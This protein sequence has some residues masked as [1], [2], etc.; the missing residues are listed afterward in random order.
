[1]TKI[2]N[3]FKLA[4]VN[5]DLDE[6]LTPNGQMTDASNVM[7]ISE[8]SGN[9][10][11]L[12][13]IKGNL[14]V[15]NTNI[16]GAE[17]IGSIADES[18]NRAFYFVKGVEFDY[19]FEYNTDNDS[20]VVV[21][22]SSVGGVLNFSTS[23]R[24]S[25]SDIFTSVEGDDLLSWTDGLNP[26][27]II[28]IERAKAFAINGFTQDEISVMKPS[29]IFAPTISLLN[30]D[31]ETT[32]NF[33][34]DKFVQ[35][36]YRYK[37]KD[38]Y[39]SAIS[40]WSQVAFL[41]S[42]FALDYQ[43]Y[44]N[45]GMVNL[46]NAVRVS[47]NVGSRDVI[48][49]DLLFKESESSTVYIVEKFDKIEEEWTT[50]NAVVNYDFI[51]N[52]IYGI[53]PESEYFRSF[54]N[55]PLT[56][57]TQSKVGNRLI[58]GNFV[59]G[60]DI[61]SK[62][63]L[64]VDYISTPLVLDEKVGVVQSV[65]KG[66]T[67]SNLVDFER[68]NDDGG[69]S[70]VDQM[71]FATNILE[72]KISTVPGASNYKL[73]VEITP[74]A[75]YAS[76]TYNF[77]IKEGSTVIREYTGL[78]G[79]NT[80]G[81]GDPIID[82]LE[83]TSDKDLTFFIT[84][85]VGL[86][87]DLKLDYNIRDAFDNFI[88]RWDYY[89]EDQLSY[90]KSGGYTST[91][92]GD[93]VIKNKATFDFT[94]FEFEGGKQFRFEFDTQSSLVFEVKP[95]F[96]FFYNLTSNY[97]NLSDF[98][99]NSDFVYSLEETFSTAFV[100]GTNAFASNE[101][102]LVSFTGFK[103]SSSGSFLTITNPHIIYD[104]TESSG[105]IEN[106]DDF[107]LNNSV[108]FGLY[109]EDAFSSMHSNRD[110][111]CDIIFLDDKGRKTTV[112]S[113]LDTALFI[114]ASNA[115]TINK[116]K[117]TTSGE[118]PS[119][120][121]YYKFAIKE[122]KREYETIYGN[123]V[124]KDGIYRWIK[125]VGEN[126]GKIKEGDELILK[127]DYA[128]VVD[129]S[130]KIKVIEVAN[131]ERDFLKGNLLESE[132]LLIEESGL[133]F[134][135][136]QGNFDINIDAD[137]NSLFEGFGKRRYASR[138]FVTTSPLFGEY[139]ESDFFVPAVVNAGTQIKFDVI[140][141]AKG[142]IAFRK[143]YSV[144]VFAQEDYPSVKDWWEAEVGDLDSWNEYANDILDDYGWVIDDGFG[145]SFRV[146][147]NR[148]GTASRDISVKVSFNINFSGGT[149]IFENYKPEQLNAPY[150]ESVE[151]FTISDGDYFSGNVL[152]P[153]VHILNRTFNC[154]TF[155]NGCESNAIKDALTSKRFYINSN[156]NAVS[157]DEYRQVHRYA[158][159]TYSGVYQE[160]TNVNRLNEF[161]LS[162][163]NYKDDLEKS[164]GPIMV[165]DSEATDLLVIQEDRFSKVLYGKDLLYNADATTNLSRIE[166]V[167][168]QQVVYGGE[169]GISYHPDSYDSYATNSFNVDV[170]RGCVVRLN[171]SNGLMEISANG[172]RDYFKTL[173]RDNIIVNVIGKYDPFFDNYIVNIKYKQSPSSAVEYVTWVYSP[174]AQGFLGRQTFNPDDM[175]RVNNHF[176]SF[177]G[178]D[179]Y[180]HNVGTYSTF[181]GGLNQSSFEFNFNQ[182]P[183]TRKIF[184]NV[185]IEGNS[186]WNITLKTDLQNGY[187]NYNDFKNKEGVYYGYVRGNDSLDMSTLAVSGIGN[188]L[189]V[190]GNVV[191][192][193]NNISTVISVGDVVYNSSLQ[194]M[195]T[196]TNLTATSITLSNAS[197]VLPNMFLLSSKPS[198][199]ETSGI[200]GYYMNVRGELTSNSYVEV[201]ALNSEVIKSFE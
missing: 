194:V 183:S 9:V 76:T 79:Q 182:E 188:V 189:S 142:S 161:N 117:V 47:F 162:L 103:V 48:G 62:I 125:I 109:S 165:L 114:P 134:K 50:D 77:T 28:N 116:I 69:T 93:T 104:V 3:N 113:G 72:A 124:Y 153:N 154:F 84:S 21:L 119:W 88:S 196:I 144:D 34:E 66:T 100:T 199:V 158:D 20:L 200:R 16:I 59:E 41:P 108:T 146:K 17:T 102:S 106:K 131:N 73:F 139:D 57:M 160:S 26:P 181:Y 127:S 7:V 138:S 87:Y 172:M 61:D 190:V 149:L 89:A 130:I 120:A 128:G 101:G 187:I 166:D 92:A 63:T 49:V 75:A 132:E 173:F 90:P 86:I 151:T 98:L 13:T 186:P 143:V 171:D 156:P 60:R 67:F 1:M 170:K 33:I 15:T 12:K 8:D 29:P 58:Y 133:Y 97:L 31:S 56:A 80:F 45:L 71:D 25:H 24:I 152:E 193:N 136:K 5:K 155:G 123:V 27:R 96:T 14:K 184:K 11:V 107:Y 35:F 22:Q 118:P 157:E 42:R 83:F 137:S 53:L 159:L 163:A 148:D 201:Y 168:G 129:S 32:S 91:L 112:I 195:G 179:V 37:Y 185:S 81:D 10:G 85:S 122:T 2:Q 52:K 169:Y 110:Y 135:I 23:Y 65:V 36:G 175:L 18:K 43:T 64:D 4:T 198:S 111:N 51:G 19:V 70:P 191:N 180:K 150:Y 40:S 192:F 147:P 176:L 78:T 164:F 121:K 54:D 141:S 6:R 44:E 99:A 94:D 197:L 30:T 167:L 140:V 38:G 82:I 39:Y 177:K 46:A 68:G 95:Q 115:D 74:K 178:A 174:E 126:K 55:V 145:T 105:V